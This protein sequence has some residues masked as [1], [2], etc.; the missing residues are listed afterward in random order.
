MKTKHF[1]S[2]LDHNRI[3]QA[4]RQAEAR[5]SGEIRV[6]VHRGE[7]RADPLAAAQQRF[8]SLGMHK[9]KQRNGVLLFVAPRAQKFAVVGDEGIHRKCGE[10]YW[11]RV[12]EKMRDHFRSERFSDALVDAIGDIGSALAQHFPRSAA[13]RDEL[14]DEIVEE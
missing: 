13:D 14:P 1:V 6:F 5:T 9:T 3:V 11:Q 12:V 10:A 7:L 8:D 2:K 4:I